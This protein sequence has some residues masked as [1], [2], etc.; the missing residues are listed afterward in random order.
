MPQFFLCDVS[1]NLSRGNGAMA[2]EFL[3]LADVAG[4][5]H[6]FKAY[7][8]PESMGRVLPFQ[9]GADQKNAGYA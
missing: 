5:A 3:D 4:L 6:E 2:K 7:C 9:A 8:M 1:I